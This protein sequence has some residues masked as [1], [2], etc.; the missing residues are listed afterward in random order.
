[1]NEDN[2][3]SILS[4]RHIGRSFAGTALEDLCPC[5]K[6]KCGLVNADNVSEDCDQHPIIRS[7]T[8]R[9]I[10]TSENCVAKVDSTIFEEIALN[11]E[12]KDS[13]LVSLVAEDNTEIAQVEL[14]QFEFQQIKNG[15]ENENISFEEHFL[16]IITEYAENENIN[17]EED[18]L[19]IIADYTKQQD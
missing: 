4:G 5:P 12:D 10:H 2:K 18:V 13:V 9:Q 19:D 8:L 7:K 15:A 16:N 3:E 17:S 6:E 14:T 1:M 11:F